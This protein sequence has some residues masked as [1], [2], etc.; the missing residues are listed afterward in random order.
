MAHPFHV[1]AYTLRKGSTCDHCGRP[2]T[3]V[4]G[5]CDKNGV[6]FEVGST[7]VMKTRDAELQAE[8]KQVQ[9]RVRQKK[10]EEEHGQE[11]ALW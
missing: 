4:Y 3:H 1:V 6:R 8:L 2:I 11:V 5:I 7:C 10:R 9:S